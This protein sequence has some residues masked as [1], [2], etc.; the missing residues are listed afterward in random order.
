MEKRKK[1]MV[2]IR[3][4]FFQNIKKKIVL[5]LDKWFFLCY[6]IIIR[7]ILNARNK[8]YEIKKRFINCWQQFTNRLSKKMLTTNF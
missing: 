2:K 1:N 5:P 7:F 4:F 8:S 3:F 6:H